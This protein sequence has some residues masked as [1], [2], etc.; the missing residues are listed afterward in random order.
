MFKICP[1]IQLTFINIQPNALH[2][3]IITVNHLVIYQKRTLYFVTLWQN[4]IYD[5]D[6][7]GNYVGLSI[8]F[9]RYLFIRALPKK[10]FARIM[11][12]VIF[13]Y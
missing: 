3:K 7:N 10:I 8:N 9:C 5:N 13:R 12:L 1:I 6:L 4:L 2:H 11:L